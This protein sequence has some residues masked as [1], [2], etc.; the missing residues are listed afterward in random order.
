MADSKKNVVRVDPDVIVVTVC[1][2]DEGRS[3]S[4]DLYVYPFKNI[5]S[6]KYI[7]M[8]I[9]TLGEIGLLGIMG[10]DKGEGAKEITLPD[11]ILKLLQDAPKSVYRLAAFTLL[12]NK[13]VINAMD[14]GDGALEELVGKKELYVERELSKYD[15]GAIITAGIKQTGIANFF[16]ALGQMMEPL[17]G[18]MTR[19]SE[20][21]T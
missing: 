5:K 20:V 9:D 17:Q 3:V 10:L 12:S 7:R 18:N 4:E 1:S 6:D 11:I 13:Q 19:E 14:A 21:S 8:A 15:V 2:D 16:G